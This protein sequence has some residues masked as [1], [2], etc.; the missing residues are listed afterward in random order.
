MSVQ[1]TL[2]VAAVVADT[3]VH[4]VAADVYT[5]SAGRIGAVLSA[6]LGLLGSVG[7]GLALAR[8]TARGRVLTWA[9][10]NG[11]VT[12]LVSGPIAVAIGATV[13][14][15]ARGG[16]GTGNGLGGAYVAILLGLTA[17]TL[18]SLAR[19]RTRTRTR[20]GTRTTH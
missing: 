18:G 13:A 4:T 19:S 7:G 3:T 14:A 8:S 5:V 2:S 20:T 9:R 15:T 17:V 12:A 10:R 6:L 16:L 11:A 1:S